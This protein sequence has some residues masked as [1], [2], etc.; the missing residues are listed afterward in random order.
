MRCSNWRYS[1][2]DAAARAVSV[3]LQAV[4]TG[5]ML[6]GGWQGATRNLQEWSSL[7]TARHQFH[8]LTH[9]LLLIKTSGWK[10]PKQLLT[11]LVTTPTSEWKSRSRRV[12]YLRSSA[13]LQ[14]LDE[15][16]AFSHW[17][18]SQRLERLPLLSRRSIL[19][20][21]RHSKFDSGVPLHKLIPSLPSYN[22]L[23]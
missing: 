2:G 20:H 6:T 7:K 12:T 23:S 5:L 19:N 21:T 17:Y 10:P 15:L 13:R 8:E 18:H 1:G 16:F 14:F 11:E 4:E 22:C 3:G 9:K